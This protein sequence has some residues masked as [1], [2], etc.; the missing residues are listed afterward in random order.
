MTTG[1]PRLIVA[2]FF[3]GETR[4][5]SIWVKAGDGPAR[6][7]EFFGWHGGQPQTCLCT[8]VVL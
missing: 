1:T 2:D 5:K 7:V 6:P 8:E 4:E 3:Y